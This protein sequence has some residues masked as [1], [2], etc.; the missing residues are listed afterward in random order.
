MNI[1]K[2]WFNLKKEK[3]EKEYYLKNS[4]DMD[5]VKAEY[6]K[7]FNYYNSMENTINVELEQ[8]RLDILIK[9]QS[10][11]IFSIASTFFAAILSCFFTLALTSFSDYF[12][13]ILKLPLNLKP[14]VINV[15]L[16]ILCL[17]PALISIYFIIKFIIDISNMGLDMEKK[18]EFSLIAQ[19]VLNDMK[20]EQSK[21]E[22]GNY[23]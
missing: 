20:I 10:N 23:F 18:I 2:K 4:N 11:P 14:T 19:Q 16:I 12:E 21:K 3:K 13:N 17:I 6:E 8:L 5:N 9:K 15:I 1:I 7:I 22:N